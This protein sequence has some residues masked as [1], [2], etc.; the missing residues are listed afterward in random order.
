M[1]TPGL[2]MSDG[3]FSLCLDGTESVHSRTV[4]LANGV[5]WRRLSDRGLEPFIGRGV[6][7]GSDMSQAQSVKG[8]AI[9]IVGGGN[10]A[11]Q[12]A[13]FFSNYADRVT[14]LVR[15]Q[16]LSTS[17]SQY[18]IDQIARS[19]NIMVETRTQVEGAGG[20]GYLEWVK[21]R[22][23][24]FAQKRRDG[25]CL[26]IMIGA[27]PRTHWLPTTIAR[28]REGYILTGE[29]QAIWPLQREPLLLET[30]LPGVF[31][32]GDVRCGSIKRVAAAVGEGS[33]AISQVHQHLG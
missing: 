30:S 3:G 4:I 29:R 9:F 10:S 25:A 12:A 13:M 15:S 27:E 33:M 28:N 26:F 2:R 19:K 24:D 21:T 1:K 6:S 22:Q 23:T 5:D 31:A 8:C 20:N 18:L 11:G 17:M 7:Y 16:S 14:L 32:V